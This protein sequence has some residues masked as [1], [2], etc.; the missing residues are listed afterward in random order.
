MN[1]PSAPDG[2]DKG[3]ALAGLRVPRRTPVPDRRRWRRR[4][5]ALLALALLGGAAI[6]YGPRALRPALEVHLVRINT[7]YPA[8]TFTLLNASGYVVPQRKAA[9]GSKITS[10]LVWLGAGEGE[11]VVSGQVVARLENAD[12]SAAQSRARAAVEVARADVAQAEAELAEAS[13]SFQRT[14]DLFTRKFVSQSEFDVGEARFK[15]ALAALAT[16][17]AS[18]VAAHAALTEAEVQLDYSAIRAPFDGV[19]L[20]KNAD[21]GDIV[22]PLGASANARASVL[23]MADPGSYQVEADVAESSIT[24]V[25]PGQACEVQLDALGDSRLAGRVAMLVPTADRSKATVLV[26]VAFLEPDPRV[27]PDMSAKVAF[28][29]REVAPAER[30]PVAAVPASAV[31]EA[32]GGSEVYVVRDGR[33]VPTPV[34]LGRSF[35]D[36]RE[37]IEGVA[38]GDSVILAPPPGLAAGQR[39]RA[40]IEE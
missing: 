24:R 1:E 16:R 18:L 39:V 20:T 8:Q 9:L 7:L 12:L 19:V 11:R 13:A 32:S 29:A 5:S 28:L 25:H 4:L 27:L 36:L 37:V 15:A 38:A 14:R 26:R 30:A 22:T 34:R 17:K 33:A 23:T 3:E 31:L 2:A 10:R 40:A 21:V 6:A 35:G